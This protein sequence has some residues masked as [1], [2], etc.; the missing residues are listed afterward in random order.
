[1]YHSLRKL[2]AKYGSYNQEVHYNISICLQQYHD[3]IFTI[4]DEIVKVG[5]DDC[6]ILAPMII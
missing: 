2:S 4:H 5:W 1:M 3:Q 6:S